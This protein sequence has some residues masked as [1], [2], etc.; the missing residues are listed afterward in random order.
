MTLARRCAPAAVALIGSSCLASFPRWEEAPSD[1]ASVAAAERVLDRSIEAHGGDPY[2][3]LAEIRVAYEGEWGFLVSKVQPVLVD[4]DYRGSSVESLVL[5]EDRLDQRHFGPAGT[6]VVLRRPDS[7]E[8]RYDTL[9]CEDP[10][11]LAAAALVADAYT[12]FLAGPAFVRRRGAELRPLESAELAG[13]PHERVL[14]RL[15]PGLG[16]SEA[17]EVVLWIDAESH[18]LDRVHFTMRGLASTRNAHVDVTFD[19]HAA[20]NG[21][22]VPRHFVERV[23]APLPIRAHEWHVTDLLVFPLPEPAPH[24]TPDEPDAKPGAVREE[25]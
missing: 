19:G 7:I 18:L 24:R 3:R 5:R 21:F 14:A 22:V 8:V 2:R 10:E 9:P 23:R 4:R 1:P 20:T 11:V 12:L 13:R 25:R 6:K 16:L 17:D 15:V